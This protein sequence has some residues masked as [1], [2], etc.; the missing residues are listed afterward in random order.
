MKRMFASLL[1]LYRLIPLGLILGL[2]FRV[3]CLG[4]R[5][6]GLGPRV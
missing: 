4:S 5:V 2:G 6:E 1:S 3:E